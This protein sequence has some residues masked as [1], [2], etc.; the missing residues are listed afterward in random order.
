MKDLRIEAS[1]HTYMVNIVVFLIVIFGDA[2]IFITKTMLCMYM[3]EKLEHLRRHITYIFI[4]IPSEV[5]EYASLLDF[6][7]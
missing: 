5:N 1:I 2:S 4:T 3:Y 6:Y 7:L